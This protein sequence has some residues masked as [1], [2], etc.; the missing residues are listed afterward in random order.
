MEA[1]GEQTARGKEPAKSAGRSMTVSQRAHP[2]EDRTHEKEIQQQEELDAPWQ[3]EESPLVPV[4]SINLVEQ[5]YRCIREVEP[6]LG[7]MM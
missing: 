4:G 2:A 5:E 7:W 3:G 6:T 1:G